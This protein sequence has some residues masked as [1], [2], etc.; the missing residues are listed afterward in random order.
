LFISNL[1]FQFAAVYTVFHA[2]FWKCIAAWG[3]EMKDNSNNAPA[4][5]EALAPPKAAFRL[6]KPP[7][8]YFSL[9][10]IVPNFIV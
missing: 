10:A 3:M 1:F 8:G 6:G 4:V 7:Q 2:F 5:R 9:V